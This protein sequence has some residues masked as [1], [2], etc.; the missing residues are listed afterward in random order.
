LSCGEA[1]GK[2]KD[3]K[4]RVSNPFVFVKNKYKAAFSPLGT[5]RAKKQ[6]GA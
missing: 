2:A 6:R 3:I 1:A 4:H 5:G